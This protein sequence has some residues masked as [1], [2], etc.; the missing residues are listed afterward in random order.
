M[1]GVRVSPSAITLAEQIRDGTEQTSY[2]YEPPLDFLVDLH[3]AAVALLVRL[4]EAEQ[5]L[6]ATY[7]DLVAVAAWSGDESDWEGSVR[8]RQCRVGT[9]RAQA[10]AVA[11]LVAV[12]GDQKE[13]T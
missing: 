2:R 4:R 10:N 9:E 11:A 8:L 5:A 6:E 1:T 7:R 12:R 13:R 3:D